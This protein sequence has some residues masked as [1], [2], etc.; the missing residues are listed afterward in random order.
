LESLILQSL[1]GGESLDWALFPHL[2]L[3][4]L[5]AQRIDAFP[6]LPRDHPLQHLYIFTGISPRDYHN[7][8]D[9]D[10]QL[11]WLKKTIYQMPTV[12]RISVWFDKRAPDLCRWIPGDFR[13]D[14]LELL[15]FEDVTPPNQN[16]QDG[17]HRVLRRLTLD[18]ET[19]PRFVT[20]QDPA[21]RRI[22]FR[23]AWS[24]FMRFISRRLHL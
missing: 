21:P 24:M 9:Y 6:P 18:P 20:T 14:D 4:G 13:E 1:Q 8:L 11:K 22:G 10:L 16:P 23:T 15:G 5:H 12:T 19:Q 2:R 17:S 7:R 3:L